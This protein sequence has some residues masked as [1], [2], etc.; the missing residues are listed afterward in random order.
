VVLTA[1]DDDEEEGGEV[2]KGWRRDWARESEK[3]SSPD[4]SNNLSG[5]PRK[6]SRSF[7]LFHLFSISSMREASLSC[8]R[9]VDTSDTKSYIIG[10]MRL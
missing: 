4:V 1:R 10:T 8:P 9:R 2:R 7:S 5:S 6:A 3:R